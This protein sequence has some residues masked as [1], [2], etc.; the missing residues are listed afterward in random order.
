MTSPSPSLQVFM[1]H[2]EMMGRWANLIELNVD[3]HAFTVDFFRMDWRR[4]TAILVAR[5]TM[6]ALTASTLAETL[7]RGLDQ[8]AAWLVE[9]GLDSLAFGADPGDNASD[10]ED[11]DLE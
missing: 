10:E 3:P 11:R 4:Q 9:T 7:D 8:H 1:R 5:V 6:S 2:D